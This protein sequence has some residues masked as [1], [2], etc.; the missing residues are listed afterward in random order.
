MSRR[1][2]ALDTAFLQ[3]EDRE[4]RMQLAGMLLFKGKAPTRAQFRDA[5][6]DRLLGLPRFQQR[7]QESTLGLARPKWV[8]DTAFDIDYHVS[9]VALPAPGGHEEVA[10]HIDQMT[11]D[12]LDLHRPLWAVGLVE[13]LADGFAISLKVHHC[14][15]DGLSIVDIFTALLAPDSILPEPPASTSKNKSVTAPQHRP[16]SLLRRV[17]DA[18]TMVGQA[19]R[20]PFNK[21]T[22]GPTRRTEYVTV[23]LDD[24]HEIRRAFGTTVNNIVL[25]LVTGA[26]RRYLERH[27]E[28]VDK[29]HAFVPVNR[30]PEAARGNLGNQIAMTYPALPVGEPSPEARVTKVI[31]SVKDAGTSGQAATTATLMG[32]LGLAPAPLARAV[33]RAVQFRSGMFNLTITNVPGPPVPAH[34]LGNELQLIL[35]S[36]PLTRKH[37]LT[38]AV[39]SYNGTL[40]FMVTTDPHRVPDGSD[41]TEDLRAEL[42][43]LK[44]HVATRAESQRSK[45]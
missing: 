34:F 29:L 39:L 8:N 15:V 35:G 32:A 7:L 38:V 2:S 27:D 33:N 9:R 37:A 41:L 36:T 5:I 44:D 10:A 40:T 16:S 20:S 22:S 21:G 3:V 31:D 43:T 6:A 25:A 28:H 19:P 12:P 24:I 1:L 26:L 17:Q 11:A 14:M 45:R 30:R 18:T 4:N 23:P 13:G 42:L